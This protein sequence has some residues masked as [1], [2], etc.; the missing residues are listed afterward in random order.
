MYNLAYFLD[1]LLLGHSFSH[2]KIIFIIENKVQ[3]K[4]YRILYDL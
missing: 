1:F 4:K 2:E 3:I